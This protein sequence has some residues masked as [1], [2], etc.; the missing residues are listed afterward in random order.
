MFIYRVLDTENNKSY[1]GL[2][3]KPVRKSHRWKCHLR[4]VKRE[5]YPQTKFYKALRGREHL[6]QYSVLF[7]TDDI[8]ELFRKEMEFIVEYD[9]FVNGYNSTLGGD[10]FSTVISCKEEYDKLSRLFSERATA[11]N[12]AKWQGMSPEERKRYTNHLHTKEIYEAKSA[13][14]KLYWED[15]KDKKQRLKGLLNHIEANKELYR[16]RA[17]SAS[18]AARMKNRRPIKL[19]N[20]LT[21][22]CYEFKTHK[23]AKL[24][25][26][27]VDFLKRKRK[28][29]KEDA[30][31][32][33]IE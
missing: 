6:F 16:E 14:L 21:D 5:K 32:E 7:E 26:I 18:D 3:T 33:I 28:I 20:R 22:E 13:T 30:T 11:Y 31:W 25:G 29:G 19:R 12:K 15:I 24:H 9:S 10:G 8:T 2:D 23:D 27:N 4:N 17:K 1:I